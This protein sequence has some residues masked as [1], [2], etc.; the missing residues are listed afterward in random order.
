MD[1]RLLNNYTN[2]HLIG[3]STMDI[4][5]F[6]RK[7]Y[8]SS[9]SIAFVYDEFQKVFYEFGWPGDEL[10]P[11]QPVT[12]IA[13]YL[14]YFVINVYNADFE[15]IGDFTTPKNT[16]LPHI[17]FVDENGLN[18]FANHPENPNAKENEFHIHT[19]TIQ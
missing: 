8:S 4:G 9:K 3:S 18:L 11:N 5:T 1:N 6:Q 2:D 17:F 10:P 13:R 15:L 16:Y 12:N 19:F 7:Y 14:P